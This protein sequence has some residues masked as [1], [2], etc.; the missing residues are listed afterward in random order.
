MADMPEIEDNVADSMQTGA[1][2]D[3]RHSTSLLNDRAI[4]R[5]SMLIKGHSNKD[6]VNEKAPTQVR[7]FSQLARFEDQ[8]S[9]ADMK[10]DYWGSL[11]GQSVGS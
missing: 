2:I 10:V 8:L 3:V 11:W 5:N 9:L 7:M 6:K 4:R 1:V